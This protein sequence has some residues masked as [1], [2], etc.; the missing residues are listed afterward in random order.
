MFRIGRNAGGAVCAAVLGAT[1]LLAAPA[2]AQ[3]AASAQ[4]V[5]P[6]DAFTD[7][8]QYRID[9]EP[10]F[11]A[12]FIDLLRSRMAN[13]PAFRSYFVGLVAAKAAVDPATHW[14]LAIAFW[15]AQ[16]PWF[17]GHLPSASGSSQVLIVRSDYW[18][19]TTGTAALYERSYGE[20]W[21]VFDPVQVNFGWSGLALAADR[22]QDTGAT[23]AGVFS[24]TQTFGRFDQPDA[25]MPYLK[26][27]ADD[28]WPY[29]PIDPR[30]Y[31][32]LQTSRSPQARWRADGDNSERLTAFGAQYDYAAVI[33]FNMPGDRY[34]NNATGE[35]ETH[36]PADTGAGGGIF[37]HTSNGRP[38]AGCV[39]LP[40][41]DMRNV[42]LRLNPAK[43]PR[44]IIGPTSVIPWER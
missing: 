32:V 36:Y 23:P 31:N 17:P 27:D 13:D 30:T 33:N 2:A 19:S 10:L 21:R 5:T 22:R 9:H 6:A 1:T 4:A 16:Q 15:E 41:D 42:L 26:F 11:K 8:L 18:S 29:D 14:A 28:Y 20:W 24:V 40:Y 37:F 38:T 34:F 39:A 12:S 25:T 43:A 7:A 3:P 35:F 44:A